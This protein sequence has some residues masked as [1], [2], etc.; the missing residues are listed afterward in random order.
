M[1]LQP[2]SSSHP[3]FVIKNLDEEEAD[4]ALWQSQVLISFNS[5]TNFSAFLGPFTFKK[6]M[7][8]VETFFPRH[9]ACLLMAF[10]KLIDTKFLHRD[11]HNCRAMSVAFSTIFPHY[12]SYFMRLKPSKADYWKYLGI[13]NLIEATTKLVNFN[14][15]M[16]FSSLHFWDPVNCVFQTSQGMLSISMLDIVAICWP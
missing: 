11:T 16:I 15:P 13:Y 6:D 7:K 2:S 12:C 10:D 1:D 14:Y 4:R 9:P 8:V 3:N 5:G